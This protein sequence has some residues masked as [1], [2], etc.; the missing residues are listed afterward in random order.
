MDSHGNICGIAGS[1]VHTV[2]TADGTVDKTNAFKYSK[3]SK[4]KESG[5]TAPLDLVKA[6]YGTFPRLATDR[7][8]TSAHPD[9]NISAGFGAHGHT[10]AATS[11]TLHILYTYILY[12]Y[13]RVCE[14][15]WAYVGMVWV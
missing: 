15:V 5:G 13:M 2:T 14:S 4:G 10:C 11:P 1:N 3:D 12:T 6:K 8:V 9:D 7:V